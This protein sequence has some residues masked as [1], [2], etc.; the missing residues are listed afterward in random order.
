VPDYELHADYNRNGR[1]DAT[2]AEYALRNTP[3]GAILVPN[4]DADA[5]RLPSNVTLGSRVTLDRDQPVVLAGD[6]EALALRIVVNT[7]GA[8]AGS[9]FFLRPQGFS[10]IRLRINDAGGRMLPVD[11]A[12]P[13]DIPAAVPAAPG[14]LDLTLTTRT[15]PGSPIGHVTDLDTRFSLDL[16]DESALLIRLLSVD[17]AGTETVHDEA[18]FTVAPFVI[19]DNSSTA[20]RAYVCDLPH[21]QPSVIELRDA[22]RL[23]G[24]P[25]LT[26]PLDVA[27]G[28]TWL[29]D[30]FQHALI[31][32]GNGWRQV[33]LHLPRLRANSSSGTSAG[34]LSTFVTSHFPSRDLGVFD[35]LWSRELQFLDTTGHPRRLG[36]RD[37]DRLA[38]V[39]LLPVTLARLL[40]DHI[41]RIDTSFDPEWPHTGPGGITTWT[42]VRGWLPELV[43]EFRRRARDAE[44]AGSAEWQAT[45]ERMAKDAQARVNEVAKRLPFDPDRGLVGLPTRAGLIEVTATE[46][47][48]IF[49]RVLQMHHS[50]NYG[51]N[52]EASPP[53]ADAALGKLVIGNG[54]ID[55]ERDFMDPDLLR[56][57]Y[58]QRKQ[59]VVQLDSTWLDVGHVDEFMAF[60][61]DRRGS[62]AAFAVLRASSDLALKLIEEAERRYLAGISV[63]HPHN[64]VRR[65][66]GVLVR[67][68][69]GG[70]SP[71]TRLFRGKVWSH[72]HPPTTGDEIP[73]ILEPP[74]IY[75]DVAQAM[76]GGDPTDPDSGGVNIHGI[77]YWPGEGPA[78]TYPADLTVRELRYGERDLDG[79][80]TN[81]FI[82]T[83]F[84]A[85]AARRLREAFPPARMLPLP[86]L[87]DRIGSTRHWAMAPSAFST[88]AFTPDVVN[89]Q[90]ING[91]LVIPRPYG[92]RMLL[93]DAIA[94]IT[95]A[96]A[97]LELPE[98]ML[99]RIDERFVRRHHLRTGVYWLQ[100][101]APVFRTVSG[102][103]T[104]RQLYDGLETEEQVIEQFRDSFPGATDSQ[105]QRNII[106]PNRTHFDAS[107]R[108]RDGWR[109][110]EIAETMVDVFETYIQAV[111]AELDVPLFWVD[112]WYY[113]VH[114]GGIHCGTNILRTPTRGST[115]PNVWNVPDLEY[116]GEPVEFE[117]EEAIVP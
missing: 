9:R 32:G 74:R 58:K 103:G 115:M 84:L 49:Q 105:L 35:D 6:D 111:A 108:L 110:F 102:I 100:R 64:I 14:A 26:V 8:P 17:A 77:R 81:A 38:V 52:I 66:S 11:L 13:D 54:V 106:R 57:L 109:R 101:Q 67:L 69:T 44:A 94:V 27:G 89:L 79:E 4:L 85:A 5:R 31:Q 93:P 18:R 53:T 47:H 62:G 7:A 37:C 56:L 21:N 91:R 29:Q 80:S 83:R 60:A 61:P 65:P 78:R 117:E 76:N 112:S 59:P 25:L 114:A 75:Q 22:L 45:L 104:V 48:R 95:A 73:A 23:I 24:V 41:K 70:T 99:R 107:G 12:R 68:T 40:T 15:L 87:F 10:R 50:S 72:T 116:G 19:L 1:L 43:N 82:E 51:G 92:P 42:D 96:T 55:G 36:F 90:A 86:V 113:H 46:A 71:V 63:D 88:S 16:E 30:Q 34:N 3:P 98:S 97:D 2:P 28:D 39:M 33:L 20:V